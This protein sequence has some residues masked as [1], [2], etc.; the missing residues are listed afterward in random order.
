MNKVDSV[1]VIGTAVFSN[2]KKAYWQATELSLELNELDLR[3][4]EYATNYSVGTL[5]GGAAVAFMI[6]PHD[7]DLVKMK[8]MVDSKILPL[9]DK[10]QFD[11]VDTHDIAWDLNEVLTISPK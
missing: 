11:I 1:L 2:N 7:G 6:R 10:F 9:F 8:K 4:S 5:P 3:P